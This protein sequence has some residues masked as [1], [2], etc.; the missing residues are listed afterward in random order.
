MTDR[1]LPQDLFVE[2]SVLGSLLIDNNLISTV[3]NSV[4]ESVFYST[5]HRRVYRC[6]C[7]LHDAGTPVDLITLT[8][9]LRRR[10]WLESV[11]FDIAGLIENVSTSTNVTAHMKILAA[12]D[13]RRK[14]ISRAAGIE[15]LA[16]DADADP[17]ELLERSEELA[18][19]I[20]D[21]CARSGIEVKRQ[22]KVLEPNE[23]DARFDQYRTFGP[24][25][26]GLSPGAFWPAT[27]T[28]F[29]PA[30]GTL[31]VLTGIP[32]HGKS[33]YMDSLA[34]NMAR[35]HNWKTLFYSPEN[36]PYE[37]HMEKLIEKFTGK[38]FG[39]L[40]DEEHNNGKKWLHDHFSWIQPDED[41]VTLN[42]LLR[43]MT[44][45]T[46]KR[47]VD[48]FVLDPWNEVEIEVA[49]K[50]ELEGKALG[51]ALTKCRWAARRLNFLYA[52]VAHPKNMTRGKNGQ[53]MAPHL[54][55]IFGG[56]MWPNKVDIGLVIYRSY[57]KEPR[58][59]LYNRACR[60]RYWGKHG[61]VSYQYV[62]P[63]VF[64]EMPPKE[65]KTAKNDPRGGEPKDDDDE[66]KGF[67]DN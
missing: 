45:A 25:N 35:D 59:T 38:P 42:T 28:I 27:S 16:F 13:L 44:E 29:R 37:T 18:S 26:P 6:M 66:L 55:D 7:Q 50:K 43:L 21:G 34:I 67:F 49:Q 22:A 36:F 56:S 12:L 23:L 57:G 58:T 31:L 15:A 32:K 10:E 14:T 33:E 46:K 39:S 30:K 8:A 54:Y 65:A 60:S 63:G 17:G 20:S 51:R 11:G 61:D 40:T 9:D 62:A 48:M 3:I 2:R 47:A 24:Q 5:A 19:E 4:D 1:I 53:Y 52:I 64:V 41:Q